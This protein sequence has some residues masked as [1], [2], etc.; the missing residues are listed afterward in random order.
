M[1]KDEARREELVQ[2]ITKAV[3]GEVASW[4]RTTVEVKESTN[5]NLGVTSG[6]KKIIKE[7]QWWNEEL[8]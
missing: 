5:K 3:D 7:T 8:Q 4:E 6:E 1:L 2:L